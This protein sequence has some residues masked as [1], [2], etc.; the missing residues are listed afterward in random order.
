M[1]VASPTSLPVG[2]RV[3]VV[4]DDAQQ[5]AALAAL[6]RLEGVAASSEHI[7]AAALARSLIE[8]PDA[9][10]LNVKMPGIS[11]TELLAALRAR[12]PDLPV[13]FLTGYEPHDPRLAAALA[14]GSVGYLA[15]PVEMPRLIEML[16]RLFE[17]RGPARSSL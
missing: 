10:V 8:P 7:A 14:S 12:Y 9:I 13:L 1:L 3:L 15:K 5:A 16:G 11:G 17:A 2:R 6:L 4:D